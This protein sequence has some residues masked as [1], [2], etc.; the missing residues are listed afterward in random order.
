[1][2]KIFSIIVLGLLFVY[3]RN[4]ANSK[5]LSFPSHPNY[6]KKFKFNNLHYMNLMLVLNLYSLL[7][8]C[9]QHMPSKLT[10]LTWL[11][12]DVLWLFYYLCHGI[13]SQ[14]VQK[15]D[16]VK[17]L[18]SLQLS[19]DYNLFLFP[20]VILRKNCELRSR[21]FWLFINKLLNTIGLSFNL[22][23]HILTYVQSLL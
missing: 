4:K 9:L 6:N 13:R 19:V 8:W 14:R 21:M 1:M 20:S 16:L 7:F 3:S 10:D 18:T 12:F 2:L 11:L 17:S 5:S 22:C 15:I 23:F